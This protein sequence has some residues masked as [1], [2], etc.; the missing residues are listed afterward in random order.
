MAAP[1][2]PVH[3]RRILDHFVVPGARDDNFLNS[4]R[5]VF[6]VELDVIKA[7]KDHGVVVLHRLTCGLVE[8]L[9]LISDCTTLV[10]HSEELCRTPRSVWILIRLEDLVLGVVEL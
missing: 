10:I 3:R 5:V 7:L 6:I 8:L 2:A 9:R 1:V 4:V